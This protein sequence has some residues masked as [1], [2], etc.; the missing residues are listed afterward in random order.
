VEYPL[1]EATFGRKWP[2]RFSGMR[3][4]LVK[5]RRE[6]L[7]SHSSGVCPQVF[8]SRDLCIV[9]L[10]ACWMDGPAY[11]RIPLNIL[12]GAVQMA[13][14][15]LVDVAGCAGVAL[16]GTP[17]VS[18]LILARLST[19]WG[20]LFSGYSI[21]PGHQPHINAFLV[22]RVESCCRILANAHGFCR[23]RADTHDFCHWMSGG[24]CPLE[25]TVSAQAAACMGVRP[26]C[27][28]V[29]PIDAVARRYHINMV[30]AG[31]FGTRSSVVQAACAV[32]L[33]R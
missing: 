7:G 2:S 9:I 29:A 15:A 5:R 11:P 12:D 23:F 30:L 21:H 26:C 13:P 10:L 32:G 24:G 4:A 31:Q 20:V 1:Y 16:V 25:A 27:G 28:A 6:G 17:S 22:M 8:H 18:R 14:C 3:T 33:S 19:H